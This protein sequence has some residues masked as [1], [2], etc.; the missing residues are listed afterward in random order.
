MT[1]KIFAALLAGILF[2]LGLTI[3][4]MTNPTVVIGFLDIMG[5]WDPRLVVVM[6]SALMFTALGFYFI[7]KRKKPVLNDSFSLPI[8]CKVDQPLIIGAIC[9]GIGWG[10]SGYCPGPAIAGVII[11]PAE[12]FPFILAMI[13]GMKI[14]H[15]QKQH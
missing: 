8:L 15:W 10:L 11:N 5:S 14:A 1:L 2:G 4:E 6:A 3:S 12:V 13:V 9:F 7:F